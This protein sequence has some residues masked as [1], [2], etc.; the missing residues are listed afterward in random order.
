MDFFYFAKVIFNRNIYGKSAWRKIVVIFV[1]KLALSSSYL[2]TN[3]VKASASHGKWQNLFPMCI[4]LRSSK[5]SACAHKRLNASSDTLAGSFSQ[6][7]FNKS[8]SFN[9]TVPF[10]ESLFGLLL[11]VILSLKVSKFWTIDF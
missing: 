7:S 1:I 2:K 5:H 11:K 8:H 4:T 9:E 6:N 3:T 10:V